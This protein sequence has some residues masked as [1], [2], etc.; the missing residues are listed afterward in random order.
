VWAKPTNT[1]RLCY[2][3]I[4][5]QLAVWRLEQIG[6]SLCESDKRK[7]TSFHSQ[8]IALTMFLVFLFITAVDCFAKLSASTQTATLFAPD[9]LLYRK[10][11]WALPKSA[12]L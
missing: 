10:I 6:E 5:K 2:L 4:A 9:K 7:Y 8:R 12:S 1:F 11:L 3:T